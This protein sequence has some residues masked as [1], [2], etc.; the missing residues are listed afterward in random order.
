LVNEIS[1]PTLNFTREEQELLGYCL[2][3]S[4]LRRSQR[5]GELLR[6]IELKVISAMPDLKGDRLNILITGPEK[7]IR[8]LSNEFS[9]NAAICLKALINKNKLKILFRS[10]KLTLDRIRPVSLQITEKKW[11]LFVAEKEESKA[12][13]IPLEEI[14]KIEIVKD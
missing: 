12:V 1:M 7:E 3:S 10:G 8:Y 9:D 13:G 5:F 14:N 2:M 6:S 11:R 4:P